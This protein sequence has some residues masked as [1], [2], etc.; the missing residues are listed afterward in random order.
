MRSKSILIWGTGIR[1]EEAFRALEGHRAYDII[2]FGDNN[3]ELWGKEKFQQPIIGPKDL[4]NCQDLDCIVVASAC[5]DDIIKQ[6]TQITN[7]PIYRSIN[8][9]MY[10]RISIEISGF[11]NARCKWCVTGRKNRQRK[12]GCSA[13][14]MSFAQFVKLHKHLFEH[15]IIEKSTEIMLYSWFE[16]LLN[17]DYVRIVEYLAEQGQKFSVSTNASKVQLLNQ[18]GAYK[19]CCSFTFSMPGFSQDSYDH[20]HGFSF[21]H[22]KKNIEEIRSDLKQSG[23]EGKGSLSFHVYQFNIH[24]VE[25][26]KV[27]AQSLDLEFH[28]Y[29]PYFNGNSMMEDYLEGRLSEELKKEAEEELFLS[30]VKELLRARPKDYKCFLENIISIDAAANLVLCCASDENCA[31]YR[32]G[33]IYNVASLEE[34]KTKRHEML[35]SGSCNKCRQLGIDFWLGN[36]P[37]YIEKEK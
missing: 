11:C 27:F 8:D 22:I 17:K 31:D 35:T 21:E 9:I 23:F 7:A 4:R 26:A 2:A 19:N 20:I 36:N 15:G 16:P 18:A 13:D 24:E 1:G 29:Y 32:W 5:T 30:H 34:M 3:E 12:E 33:S 6:L 10:A 14:Y 25:K 37:T 28:P